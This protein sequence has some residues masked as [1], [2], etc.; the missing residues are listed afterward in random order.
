MVPD[1]DWLVAD[2]PARR[3]DIVE[4]G[5]NPIGGLP[6]PALR[7]A[8]RE[9][10]QHFVKAFGIRR[11]VGEIVG[12][13]SEITGRAFVA[14][15][16]KVARAIHHQPGVARHRPNDC[17]VAGFCIG[18][19]ALHCYPG[20]E[21]GLALRCDG[22]EEAG[23]VA[24]PLGEQQRVGTPVM[25]VAREAAAVAGPKCLLIG[26]AQVGLAPG[27]AR[28]IQRIRRPAACG[29]SVGKSCPAVASLRLI[30]GEEGDD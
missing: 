2:L 19:P 18:G 10:E 15:G 24:W 8:I 1:S 16:A 28:R 12:T 23:R 17:R 30:V 6:L 11:P 21:G 4:L 7:R 29:I 9:Q 14:A 22:S 5:R 20:G 26:D 13:G 25:V 27:I 3:E